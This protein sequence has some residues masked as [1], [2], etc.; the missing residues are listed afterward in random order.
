MLYAFQYRKQLF[1][2]LDIKLSI[3]LKFCWKVGWH[4]ILVLVL[5]LSIVI[6]QLETKLYFYPASLNY[7]NPSRNE[8]GQRLKNHIC[9]FKIL[10]IYFSNNSAKL[11]SFKK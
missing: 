3:S 7:K 4:A 6:F 9:M 5:C 11:Y 10:P 2:Q 1:I 8:I